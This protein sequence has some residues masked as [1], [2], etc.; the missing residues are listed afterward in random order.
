MLWS[1]GAAYNIGFSNAL[2]TWAPALIPD[3]FGVVS[4]LSWLKEQAPD[5][6]RQ[7]TSTVDTDD[8]VTRFMSAQGRI[9]D[10]P[11][12]VT[13]LA[14][15]AGDVVIGHPWLLHCA[16]ENA[17]AGPRFMRTQDIYRRCGSAPAT[18]AAVR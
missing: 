6:V 16:A 2:A 12:R 7:L 11:V 9:G 4:E 10:V 8:R 15:S 5:A 14:G 17:G 13:E 1:E 18:V 3:G